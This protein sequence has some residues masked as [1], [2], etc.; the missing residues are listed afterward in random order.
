MGQPWLRCG[1]I[2]GTAGIALDRSGYIYVADR[3]NHRVQKFDADGNFILAWG[4]KGG[5]DGQFQEP[6]DVATSVFNGQETIYVT[7][8]GGHRIQLFNPDG[9]HMATW[10]RRSTKTAPAPGTYWEPTGIIVDASQ[11]VYVADKQNGRIQKMSSGAEDVK[12]WG[13]RGTDKGQFKLPAGLAIGN[14]GSLYIADQENHRVQKIKN[15]GDCLVRLFAPGATGEPEASEATV[16]E[17][18]VEVVG[19]EGIFE[20]PAE[21]AVDREGRVLV[22]DIEERRILQFDQDGTYRKAWGGWE[23]WEQETENPPVLADIVADRNRMSLFQASQPISTFLMLADIA[24]DRDNRVFATD[25]GASILPGMGL[26]DPVRI[27]TPDGT[28]VASW[29]YAPADPDA[30]QQPVGIAFDGAGDIYLADAARHAIQ[31]YDEHGTL[32]HSWGAEGS[33]P[34]QFKNPWNISIDP[35]DHIY[36]VDQGNVRLQKFDRNGTWLASWGRQG[37]ARGAFQNIWGVAADA[38]GRVYASDT[39][40]NSIQSFRPMTYTAPIATITFVSS[41]YLTETGTLELYG[42]GQDSDETPAVVAY[43]W[44]SDRQ[45]ELGTTPTLTISASELVT[46]THVIS[47][48][49]RDEEGEW[50]PPVE[51]RVDVAPAGVVPWVMLLYLAGDYHD[52]QALQTAF[53]EVLGQLQA[54]LSN[55]AVRIA[56]QLD[57]PG[58]G[59]SRRLLLSPGHPPV[60]QM[61]ERESIGEQAMDSPESLADFIRWGQQQFPAYNS[62]YYLAIANHGQ[63]VRGIAWDA[64]SDRADDGQ[65]NDSAYLTIK[66]LRQALEAPGV[67]PIAVLHLDACS[68]NLLEVAYELRQRVGILIASQYL[69]WDFFAYNDYAQEMQAETS[70]MQLADRI[71][72]RYADRVLQDPQR[73][74]TLAALDLRYAAAAQRTVANWPQRSWLCWKTAKSTGTPWMCSGRTVRNLTPTWMAGMTMRMRM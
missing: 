65:E 42:M 53:E 11:S 36:V 13:A 73:P 21:V 3:H 56:V 32:L 8:G 48:T 52:E 69:A 64:T 67:M 62:R 10:G 30:P 7:D 33:G 50:S 29:S 23:G 68:M 37:N 72:A 59:D 54:S 49:V 38:T 51:T 58:D 61:E 26:I 71:V 17:R 44:M 1:A 63:G 5:E 9:A 66:E 35:H 34:G 6:R 41:A 14:D 18:C 57:G 70:P 31:Q 74:Y 22:A 20:R 15:E 43:R 19:D 46:G 39:I 40:A 12:V 55:E 28:L 16:F 24:V 4:S 27:F 47:L 25:I 45:G 60:V 2:S